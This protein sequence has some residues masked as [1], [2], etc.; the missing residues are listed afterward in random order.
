M[1]RHVKAESYTKQDQYHLTVEESLRTCIMD[2][3]YS[4][5]LEGLFTGDPVVSEHIELSQMLF[6]RSL[7]VLDRARKLAC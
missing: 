2:N 6:W 1:G 5:R 7:S 3:L 4:E